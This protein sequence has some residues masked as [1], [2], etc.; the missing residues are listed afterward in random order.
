MA[1]RSSLFRHILVPHDFSEQATVALTTAGRL[2]KAHG[3]KL[4][5]LYV[6]EPFCPRPADVPFG[7]PTL[8]DLVR[9]QKRLL[10]QLVTKTLGRSRPRCTVRVEVG[11]AA[12]HIIN[13]G[14]G[15]DSIVMATSGRTGIAHFLVGSVAERVVRHASVPVLTLR[16]PVKKRRRRRK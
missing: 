16:V 15:V 8:G 1:R 2:A 14:R 11:G 6:L 13:A 3:G 4:S 12:K 5:V 7:M 9:E 10:E